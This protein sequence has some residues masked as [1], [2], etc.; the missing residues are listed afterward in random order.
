MGV[1]E[2]RVKENN[3]LDSDDKIRSPVLLEKT[4][5]SRDCL[6]GLQL[7]ALKQAGWK[8]T[9]CNKHQDSSRVY[10][11][12]D[13]EFGNIK[14]IQDYGHVE[15][16]YENPGVSN[17]SPILIKVCPRPPTRQ[18]PFKLFHI[19]M[20]HPEFESIVTKMWG[21]RFKGTRMQQ[22]WAKLKAMRSG[23]RGLNAYMS[24]YSQKLQKAR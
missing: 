24:T 10:S 14:W 8:Y 11:K 17:H 23:S 20:N 3:V 16:I 12:I 13:R 19:V 9:F 7:S 22:L 15:A 18:R 6:D 4:Q 1:L 2:T 21:R 5:H